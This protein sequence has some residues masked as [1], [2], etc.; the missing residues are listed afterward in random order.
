MSSLLCRLMFV[1]LGTATLT[2]TTAW[3]GGIE[4]SPPTVASLQRM[5]QLTCTDLENRIDVVQ[6]ALDFIHSTRPECMDHQTYLTFATSGSDQRFF[7]HLITLR[8]AYR[9]FVLG[10]SNERLPRDFD[11][12]LKKVFPFISERAKDET[13]RMRSS[14]VDPDSLCPVVYARGKILDLAEAKRRLFMNVLSNNPLEEIEYRWGERRGP[15]PRARFCP[16][17][18]R[19]APD[20]DHA[21]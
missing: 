1:L 5:T 8:K 16:A 6:D 20:L 19:W 4:A 9:A 11:L 10:G 14:P 7:R 12:K 2:Q 3:A 21:D 17:W 15:S 13:A 18:N